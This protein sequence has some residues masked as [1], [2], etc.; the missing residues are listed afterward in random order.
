[1]LMRNK[2][3]IQ[4]FGVFLNQGKAGQDVA[5]AEA[6]INQ[7]ARFFGA[8]ES[9]ISRAAG[10]EDADLDYDEPP[11]SFLFRSLTVTAR[12]VTAR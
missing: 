2:D 6:G 5:P 12:L 1:M 9:G 8:D 11:G 10:G 7:D 4:L 3:C